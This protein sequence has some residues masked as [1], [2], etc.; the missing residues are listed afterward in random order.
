MIS[1]SILQ[2]QCTY[3]SVTLRPVIYLL[4]LKLGVALF[5]R[6]GEN[7]KSAYPLR[8]DGVFTEGVPHEPILG[9]RMFFATFS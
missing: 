1:F 6:S 3:I 5:T 8:K 7:E 9:V 4:C 2:S